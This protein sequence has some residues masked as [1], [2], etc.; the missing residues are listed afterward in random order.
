MALADL[1]ERRR[2]VRAFLAKPVEREKII[3]C[4]EAA[5]L[6]PSAC[7]AQPWQFIVVD[8]GDV[9]ERMCR[10]AFGGVYKMNAFCRQAPV[11]V[12]II[13]DRRR[14][15]TAFSRVC[16]AAGGA[17]RR[18]KYYLMD[19]GIAGE[20]FVLQAEELGLGTCWVGWFNERAVKR[21]LNIPR[22]EKIDALIAVGYHRGG[23][24]LPQKDRR[25]MDEVASFNSYST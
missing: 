10:G 22:Y 20:H 24:A 6:A 8:D 25:P 17:L 13:S 18:T 16:A 1:I 11:I 21:A 9:R 15:F 14:F 12:A 3:K 5:R 4:L 19:I 7:N 2:S 23:R